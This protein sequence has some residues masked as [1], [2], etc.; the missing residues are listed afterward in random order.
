M[1]ESPTTKQTARAAPDASAAVSETFPGATPQDLREAYRVA[2][3][4]RNF[5]I[6]LFWQRSNYFLVL[7]T[8]VAVGFFTRDLRHWQ[9]FVLSVVGAVVAYLW[10][11]VN[12]GGKF[13]QSRWEHRLELIER[14]VAPQMGLFAADWDTVA[15]DVEESLRIS[16]SASR[17]YSRGFRRAYRWA[18]LKKP[19]VSRVMTVMSLLFVLLWLGAAAVAGF[20]AVHHGSR[21]KKLPTRTAP[22]A[23][24][25]YR[26][27]EEAASPNS[28]RAQLGQKSTT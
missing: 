27:L 21:A 23:L 3:D 10:L 6:G 7:N 17:F 11:L 14:E 15:G 13:W 1:S 12:L 20:R 24:S 5:E 28:R 22:K 16:Y 25:G 8:A 4:T 19:S 26:S 9:A 2:L 18:V